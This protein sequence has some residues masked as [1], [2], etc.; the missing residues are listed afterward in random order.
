[1][2]SLAGMLP[3]AEG[4]VWR[5]PSI[6]LGYLAQEHSAAPPRRTPVDVLRAQKPCTEE[7]A[8]QALLRFLFTYEQ[9]RQPV[10]SFSGGERT[11]LELLLLMRGGANFLVLDEPTNHLDIDSVETLEAAIES[12]DGTVVAV[13]HD[14]YFLD[15]IADRIVDVSGGEARAF[16]GGYS[17]W[18]ARHRAPA[19]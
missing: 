9:C 17:T 1:M 15:R 18:Y 2:K 13:S 14:R 12:Y 3:P 19:A 6:Q 11:R 8:V 10:A 16:E 7:E 4:E 5:G